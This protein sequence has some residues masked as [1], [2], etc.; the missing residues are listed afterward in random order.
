M[1]L[2][3]SLFL[4]VSWS[5][6]IMAESSL[7]STP[8]SSRSQSGQT[9]EDLQA[10][11][12]YELRNLGTLQDHDEDEVE[13]ESIRRG[14]SHL[15]QS[16]NR[17]RQ[18]QM[19][20]Y[21]SRAHIKVPDYDVK[22]EDNDPTYERHTYEEEE[23]IE[24]QLYEPRERQN[25]EDEKP[26]Q[27]SFNRHSDCEIKYD[28]VSVV[29]QVP[30]FTKHCHKVEDTK[31]KTIFKNAFT[32]TIETQCTATFDTSCDSTLETAFK[33][34]CK[35]IKDV[36]CRI[37]N[38]EDSHGGHESKKI[39]ED[40]PTEKCVPVPVKVEGQQC[41]NVP[42][43]KCEN[44]PV[45]ASVPVPKQQCFKKPRK[46]CQTLVSTKPKV[47]TA[48]VPREHCGHDTAVGHHQKP[49]LKKSLTLAK[50]PEKLRNFFGEQDAVLEPMTEEIES[51]NDEY[52]YADSSTG[53]NNDEY[54]KT[55]EGQN[56]FANNQDFDQNLVHFLKQNN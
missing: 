16:R 21:E 15:G 8:R 13:N 50:A 30:S 38:L 14:R 19:Q 27:R 7:D 51:L 9:I 4:V 33:Q 10:V 41:V 37:V 45:T 48:Q 5:T 18:R 2:T 1:I 32:T 35:I 52:E 42:V 47:V 43:Q 49:T 3:T 22:E 24:R 56:K 54:S 31:C 11:D 34:E 6:L 44:V 20:S 29:K 17:D 55:K 28:T 53:N 23:P 36:E 26:A 39:C 40:V 46:V 25:F 12:S